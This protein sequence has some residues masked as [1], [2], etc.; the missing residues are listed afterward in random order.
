M[1]E[2]LYPPTRTPEKRP[3]VLTASQTVGPFFHYMLTPHDYPTRQLF[4][5]DLTENGVAGDRI[6]IEGRV[7]DGDGE[8]VPDAVIEIWQA[9]SQ[10]RYA[11]PDDKRGPASNNFRG[12]G[13]SATDKDGVF[14][15]VTVKPGA[16]PGVNGA[17]QAPH[18]AVNVLGRGML[19][20]L[21]TRIYFE[22]EATNATD[23]ILALVP[24]ER[25]STLI[26]RRDTKNPSLYRFDIR[27]QGDGE[28]VFFDV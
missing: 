2:F 17:T 11:H 18:I 22:G 8:A 3:D 19:I 15:F 27:L 28:T 1:T 7:T 4:T 23:G 12:F 14:K 5:N 26:A 25:R 6:V 21:V 13:R 20:H 10:G 24:A 16:V 9:D